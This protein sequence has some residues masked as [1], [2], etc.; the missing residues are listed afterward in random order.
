MSN[1]TTRTR[2]RRF[3]RL[4]AGLTVAGAAVAT[5]LLGAAPAHAQSSTVTAVVAGGGTLVVKGTSLG[6]T[7]TAENGNGLITVSSSTPITPQ[8]GCSP[9]VAG[10]VICTGVTIVK[11][12]GL[13][14]DDTLR[15]NSTTRA[16]LSGGAANDKL[17]GGSPD[18][19]L[20]GGTGID[21]ADGNG[22]FDLCVAETEFDC[23]G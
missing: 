22:G 13:G 20:S 3:S 11:L 12:S 23:E 7:I 10:K 18:D 1:T 21:Q 2:T 14:G 5:T 9:G 16:E 15:N 8:F 6:E 17:F 19:R 4:A